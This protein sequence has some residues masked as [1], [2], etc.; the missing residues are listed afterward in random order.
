MDLNAAS[1]K[2]ILLGDT[3]IME[4][5]ERDQ[6]NNLVA[7]YIASGSNRIDVDASQPPK[8]YWVWSVLTNSR[9]QKTGIATQKVF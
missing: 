2:A 4:I 3:E 7:T 6:A 5:Q 1:E 9:S 8:C